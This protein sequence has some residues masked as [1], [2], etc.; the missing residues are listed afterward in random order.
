MGIELVTQISEKKVL[1]IPN[2]SK[3]L[4]ILEYLFRKK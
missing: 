3:F 4:T 1:C 2:F